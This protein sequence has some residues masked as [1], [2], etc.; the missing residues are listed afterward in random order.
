MKTIIHFVILIALS[1]NLQAQSLAGVE[2]VEYD[3]INNRYLTSS[4]N[5]SIVA[6]APNGALSYFGSGAQASHG[7]EVVGAALYVIDGTTIRCYDLITENLIFSQTV[8]GSQF[9]NGMT[10]NGTDSIWFTD[11][12]GKDIYAMDVTDPSNY[13]MI[14]QNISETP[15]GIS[16][17]SENNRC[18]FVTW[19]TG[20]VKEMD[21]TTNV[22]SDVVANTGLF[23]IDGIDRDA[24]GNW[25][26]SSW[27]N[28]SNPQITKYTNDFSSS[29]TIT[30][31]GIS[32]PADICYAP[33]T[34]TLAIPGGDQVLF[35]GFE[36]TSVGIEEENFE[37]YRIHYNSGYPVVQFDF[38]E[39]Q[40]AVLEIVD[41][42]GRVVYTILDGHQPKGA[43]MVVFSSIGLYSGAYFCRLQSKE[44]SFAERIIIP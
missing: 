13:T 1:V 5:T 30:V 22:I 41:M 14:V 15:N 4:D 10:S 8:S 34:D 26:L 17:D 24:Q 38:N 35:V 31:P 32:S 16:Y 43:Q 3:P 36:S 25:Y 33:E 39:D 19:G 28:S 40:D 37:A 18:V 23:N 42:S 2:S 7:M 6:I 29:E 11:F 9:L 20:K 12:S 21:L 44:L 27:G